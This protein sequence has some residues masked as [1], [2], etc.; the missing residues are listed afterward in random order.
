MIPETPREAA[1]RFT[2]D[3]I[4]RHDI[5]STDAGGWRIPWFYATNLRRHVEDLIRTERE[6]AA[7]SERDR[8]AQYSREG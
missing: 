3:F 4:R 1:E 7:K 6:A 8:L 2:D 5:H